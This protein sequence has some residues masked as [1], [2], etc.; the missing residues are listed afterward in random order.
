MLK[1]LSQEER[2]QLE[3]ALYHWA[4]KLEKDAGNPQEPEGVRQMSAK[5]LE[6][7][8]RTISK[9]ETAVAFAGPPK[10]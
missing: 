1:E 9:Y 6:A 8:W 4:D 7:T 3:N 2:K 10:E 5:S